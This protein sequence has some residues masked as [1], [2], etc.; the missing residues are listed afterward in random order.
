MLC[1]RLFALS[2]LFGL[3]AFGQEGALIAP[4]AQLTI[5]AGTWISVRVDDTVSTRK[6]KTGDIFT[7]TLSQPII[8]DGFVVARRGQTVEGRVSEAVKAGR[9]K[10]TARLGLELTH[11]AAADGQ[12]VEIATGLMDRSGGTGHSNDAAAVGTSAGLGAMIGAAADNGFGAGMGAIAGGGAAAIGV[13]LTRGRDAT[14]YP[15]TLVRFRTV[16][17][18]NVSTERSTHAFRAVQQSDYE[19]VQLARRSAPASSRRPV[20]APYVW[21]PY[22]YPGAVFVYNRPGYRRRGGRW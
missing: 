2:L 19:S 4:P 20:L 22:M 10:G 3:S 5:P 9:I 6:D 7:A 18:V 14:V 16:N 17:S 21:Y 12:R 15:E 13:L 1:S 8:V 11:F